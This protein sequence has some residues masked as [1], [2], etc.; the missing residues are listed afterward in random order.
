M[1]L[2]TIYKFFAWEK[3]ARLAPISPDSFIFVKKLI[4]LSRKYKY[5]V[6]NITVLWKIHKN[7]LKLVMQ[8]ADD[9]FFVVG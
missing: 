8:F 2:H 1:I 9:P 6:E 3:C 5:L 7:I 4:F